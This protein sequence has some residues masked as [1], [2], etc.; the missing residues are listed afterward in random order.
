MALI[1]GAGQGLMTFLSV[2]VWAI[3][4][5]ISL[6]MNFFKW[7]YNMDNIKLIL[8]INYNLGALLIAY[9]IFSKDNNIYYRLILATL[10]FG[11]YG[12]LLYYYD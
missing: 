12:Y 7:F 2:P 8:Q 5:L 1:D 6:V 11:L 4:F 3:N 10:F 9:E